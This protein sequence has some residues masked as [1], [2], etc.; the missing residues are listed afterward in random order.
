MDKT[1]VVLQFS[2]AHRQAVP[3]GICWRENET[4]D[5]S[6]DR[7]AG[8]AT[9][10]C[11]MEATQNVSL[12]RFANDL[13][14]AG[15]QLIS[16]TAKVR[17][18]YKGDSGRNFYFM[19]RCVFS[20]GDSCTGITTGTPERK[21]LDEMV[22]RVTW[23]VRIYRNTQPDGSPFISVNAEA[24][25][26][27]FRPDGRPVTAWRKDETGERVGDAPIPLRPEVALRFKP[28]DGK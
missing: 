15:Y 20:R 2:F 14:A 8:P 1:D 6:R 22:H 9:G 28:F 17:R 25:T 7:K 27:L 23:R 21:A 26:P 10:A 4:V 12:T 5:E 11:L 19:V 13:D 16:M 24:R 3:N 18:V